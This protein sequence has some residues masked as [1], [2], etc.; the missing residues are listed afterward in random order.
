MNNMVLRGATPT[1]AQKSLRISL[2]VAV[3]A[4][5]FCLY[6]WG[7]SQN[8][9]GFYLDESATAYNAY[10]ISQTGAGEFGPRFP[11]LFQQFAV[12]NAT[13]MNPLAIYLMAIVFRF[14]PPSVAVARISAAFWMFV[15][16]LLIGVLAK[17]ISRDSKIGVIVAASALL[18]P[19]FFELGR[20]V[21]DAHLSVFTVVVFLL[22][23]YSV[24]SKE[25]WDW[26][27]IARLAG[28]LALVTC[29]CFA[30]RALA[31]LF[32]VGLL[33]FATTKRFVGVLK[34]WLA[35]GLTL[36]PLVLF[37]RSILAP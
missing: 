22:A 13:C 1:V 29:G 36:M 2:C 3:L 33:S 28:A 5:L 14:V 24:Q 16:C 10:L 4:L 37:D 15:A 35:Y 8:P 34:V 19:W 30:G 17:R 27:D 20:L 25:M 26:R 9:R 23:I 12:S 21:F 18:T 11:L 32:A 6:T 7:I 31:P